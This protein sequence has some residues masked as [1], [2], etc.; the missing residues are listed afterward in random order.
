VII[1]VLVLELRPPESA[2]LH[3][4]LQLW[5][6]GVSYGVSYLFI[7]VVW[8]NHHHL[9]RYAT[10]ATPRLLWTN[11]AHL[12]A[13]SLMPFA[14]AWISDTRLAAPTPV[15][16]YAGVFVLVNATYIV[17]CWETVDRS[18]E[19]RVDP[20]ARRMMRLR[21]WTTLAVFASAALTALAL[22]AG[23]MALIF[24]T[25]VVYLRPEAPGRLRA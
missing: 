20:H 4:L 1:T 22:P 24:A 18:P 2:S 8:L 7:A 19:V 10:A 21:S 9:M 16:L 12:F 15:A 13:V 11:F 25:L 3:A 23:G 14:T 17:L 6:T 5:P